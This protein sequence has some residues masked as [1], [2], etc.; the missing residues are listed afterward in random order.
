MKKVK[1]FSDFKAFISKGNILDMAVGVIIGG[2]FGK[3][4]SSL[5]A[6]IIMPIIGRLC[7]TKSL[8][9]LSYPEAVIDEAGVV[10]FPE[11]AI[12]YGNFIMLVVDFLIVALCMFIVIRTFMKMRAK[13]EAR[14]A[15]EEAAA[16]A[17]APAAPAEPTVEEKTLA[18]LNDIKALLEKNSK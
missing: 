15:A 18:T 11:G 12:K 10:T 14:K 16:A 8:A 3:I 1:F 7:N 9:N 17:E 5:V 4:V 6:D 13:A 2:A